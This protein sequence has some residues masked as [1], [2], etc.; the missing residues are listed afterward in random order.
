MGIKIKMD[1]E[2]WRIQIDNEEWEFK[3]R[4]EM[5][6]N[7]KVLLDMKESKGRIRNND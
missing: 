7:L 2:N 6:S 5:E 3:S 1:R 4:A